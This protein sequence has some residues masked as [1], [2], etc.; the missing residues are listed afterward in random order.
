MVAT[1]DEEAEGNVMSLAESRRD[2]L[3]SCRK[4][5]P[6]GIIFSAIIIMLRSIANTSVSGTY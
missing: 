6:C 5:D 1:S 4:Q 3:A 2:Q